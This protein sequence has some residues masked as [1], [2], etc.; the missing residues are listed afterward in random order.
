MIYIFAGP[1]ISHDEIKQHLD[2]VCLPP[3][4][5]GDILQVLEAKPT[6][7]GIIDGYFEGAPSVWHKEILYAL[8]QGVHVFGSSSMGALRAAELYPFGMKGVG[9]IF[10]WYKE[11]VIDADDEVAVLHGPAEIGYLAVSEPLVNI[12]ATL[13]VAEQ[14]GKISSEQKERLFETAK[15]TYYKNRSW[16]VFMNLCA[17]L[18]GGTWQV[19]HLKAWFELNR[20]DLKKQDALELLAVLAQSVEENIHPFKSDFYFENTHVWSA[21]VARHEQYSNEAVSLSENQLMVLNQLRL[22]PGLYEQYSNKALIVWLCDNRVEIFNE[23]INLKQ[24]LRQFR[25]DNNLTSHVQLMDC[26]EQMELN[27]SLLAELLEGAC[28]AELVRLAAGSLQRIIIQ[29]L[30]LDGTFLQLLDVYRRKQEILTQARID[31]DTTTVLPPQILTWYFRTK[32]GVTLPLSLDEHLKRIDLKYPEE[33]YRLITTEY[34][35]C[36]EANSVNSVK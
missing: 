10:H 6:A 35:Y 30:K 23:D 26:L 22:E 31:P 14:H 8:D 27:E 25:V 7:I 36:L 18:L 9:Q 2:C 15:A 34:L 29:Q 19:T 16:A 11:G 5:H 28:R 3:V 33:F 32:L 12:R 24:A 1:T 4:C 21:A 17:E 20:V 13:V